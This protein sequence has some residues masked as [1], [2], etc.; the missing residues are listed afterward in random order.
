MYLL[1]VTFSLKQYLNDKAEADLIQAYLEKICNNFYQIFNRATRKGTLPKFSFQAPEINKK[2][3]ALSKRNASD[4]S[5][6]IKD[7]NMIVDNIM[8]LTGSYGPKKPETTGR[9]L[10]PS[11]NPGRP[12]PEPPKQNPIFNDLPDKQQ[13]SFFK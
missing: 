11:H 2:Y 9:P 3:K 4:N 6:S 1:V 7:Y 12:E 10:T 8:T 13:S 5:T